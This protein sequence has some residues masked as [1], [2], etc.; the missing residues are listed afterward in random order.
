MS[1]F[2]ISVEAYIYN[3]VTEN[4]N[5]CVIWVESFVVVMSATDI[6]SKGT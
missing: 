4:G 3:S 1:N 6:C 2:L 5:V